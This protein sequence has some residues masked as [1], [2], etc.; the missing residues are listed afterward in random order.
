MIHCHAPNERNSSFRQPNSGIAVVLVLKC[1]R[2]DSKLQFL[3]CG[4]EYTGNILTLM[5]WE[6]KA[7]NGSQDL[8]P[9]CSILALGSQEEKQ[10]E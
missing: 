5:G 3:V 9:Q 1:N 2:M 10:A 4:P 6:R 8:T 7:I